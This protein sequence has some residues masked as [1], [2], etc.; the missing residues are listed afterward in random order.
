MK[1]V[2]AY[3]KCKVISIKEAIKRSD[4]V[5]KWEANLIV[6]ELVDIKLNS[7]CTKAPNRGFYS[8]IESL[9]NFTRMDIVDK[10]KKDYFIDRFFES[11]RV[12]NKVGSKDDKKAIDLLKKALEDKGHLVK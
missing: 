11:K 4:P 2:D 10:D 7:N 6:A 1:N 5:R 8:L 12:I 9:V 3:F